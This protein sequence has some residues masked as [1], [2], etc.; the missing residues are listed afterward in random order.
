MAGINHH[1]TLTAAEVGLDTVLLNASN[2]SNTITCSG[3]N[4]ASFVFNHHTHAGSFDLTF[5][6]EVSIDDGTTWARLQI[7]DGAA[8]AVLSDSSFKKTL[9]A[10]GVFIVDVPL[11]YSHIRIK[12]LTGGAAGDKM[13]VTVRLGAI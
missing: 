1:K 3:M 12:A 5:Y 10:T 7:E 11:N 6:F 13:D 2:D 8:I 9:A 4:Q